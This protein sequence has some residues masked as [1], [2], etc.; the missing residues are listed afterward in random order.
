[1]FLCNWLAHD[2]HHIRQLNTLQHEYLREKTGEDL[3][4]A[5]DW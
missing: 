2:Q 4:Y 5:G 3:K 1:M